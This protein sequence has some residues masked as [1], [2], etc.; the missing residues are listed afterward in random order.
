VHQAT[1]GSTDLTFDAELSVT[2]AATPDDAIVLD[3]STTILART[4]SDGEWSALSQGTFATADPTAAE[5][6]AGFDDND[7]FEF[8]EIFNPSTVGS[9]NLAG[10]QLAGGVDFDFG[11]FELSP[12][13]RVV[14]VEDVDAFRFRYGDGPTVLGQWSGGL[15]NGGEELILLADRRRSN[16]RLGGGQALPLGGQHHV[17]RHAGRGLGGASGCGDQ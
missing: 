3:A 17:Q 15:S 5:I 10:L 12:G 14:V 6:A 2:Q 9:V 13:Q 7:D 8:I 4:F 11:D 1:P 16:P